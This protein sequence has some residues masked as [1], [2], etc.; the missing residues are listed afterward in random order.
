M[1]TLLTNLRGPA[2]Y[3]ATGAA[4]DDAAVAAFV[5]S[6]VGATETRA[7]IGES[8]VSRR[9]PDGLIG[10]GRYDAF[11]G[12]YGVDRVPRQAMKILSD[13]ATAHK[14]IACVGHSLVGGSGGT[15]PWPT[16]LRNALSASI[17]Q[18]SGIVMATQASSPTDPQ[19]T[20]GTGWNRFSSDNLTQFLASTTAGSLA[21][22]QSVRAGT[23]VEIW[24]NGQ[25]VPFEYRIDGGSWVTYT[26]TG[27]FTAQKVQVSGL[28]SATHKV[29][30][31]SLTSG[32]TFLYGVEVRNTTG[33]SITNLGAGG[34]L[35]IQW[36]DSTWYTLG[37][38]MSHLGPWDLVFIEVSTNDMRNNVSIPTYKANVQSIIGRVTSAGGTV[39]LMVD[40]QPNTIN[41][42]SY[43]GVPATVSAA[44]R[45]AAYDLG[46]V[47]NIRVLD[48]QG[49]FGPYTQADADGM[50]FDSV[51]L[52]EAGY[53]RVGRA[54]DRVLAP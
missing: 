29:E 52:A 39:V 25:S 53:Q 1:S 41:A 47:N 20:I 36:N 43:A 21:T 28:A 5:R 26:P 22:F 34:S 31:R 40:P 2:G 8:F 45:Q 50:M 38:M 10:S 13:A 32:N 3:N 44:Y 35:S 14:K 7:A 23:I 51:H 19:W 30:V 42:G 46:D 27:T 17:P 18:N 15:T 11:N 16:R 48:L 9:L 54:A 24:T 6:P 49:F 33:L 12:I 37:P 4:E